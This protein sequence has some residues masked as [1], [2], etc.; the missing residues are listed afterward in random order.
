MRRILG[1]ALVL[2]P[3][4]VIASE[5]AAPALDEQGAESLSLAG[6]H[7]VALR[8]WIWGGLLAAAVLVPAVAGLVHLSRGSR[9][10]LGGA[11]LA[12]VGVVGYAAHQALFMQIPTLL[13]GDRAEMAALY[14]R[15][16]QTAESGVLI[17]LVFLVPLFLGLTLLG[18]AAYR[19]RT[20]PLW[21]AVALGLAFVPGFLPIPFDAGVLSFGLLLAALTTYGVRVLRMSDEQW[22]ALAS[23]SGAPRP[24]SV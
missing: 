14:E 7:L 3:I 16:G 21:P 15:Q 6:E 19:A 24:V 5:I 23:P 18:I 20:A 13:Q 8:L 9:L 22:A 4:L 1:S 10:S 12:V 17:F 2:A 11:A